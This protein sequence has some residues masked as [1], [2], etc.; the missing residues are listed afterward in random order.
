MTESRTGDDPAAAPETADHLDGGVTHEPSKALGKAGPHNN[1]T[2]PRAKH[3]QKRSQPSMRDITEAEANA[4]AAKHRREH[5]RRRLGLEP[6]RLPT[7]QEALARRAAGWEA[8][9]KTEVNREE[10]S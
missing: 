7:P 4:L 2:D 10:P 9:R 6:W 3:R 5:R 1:H 8:A